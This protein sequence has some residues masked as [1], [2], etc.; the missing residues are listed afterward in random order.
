MLR[1]TDSLQCNRRFSPLV[2]D[3]AVYGSKW[4]HTMAGIPSPTDKPI[5]EG[6]R[7]A[8]KRI[9]GLMRSP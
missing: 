7:R 3:S 9:S 4:A 5:I 2:V 8:S 6:V 1:L